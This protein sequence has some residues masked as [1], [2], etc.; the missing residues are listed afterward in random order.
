MESVWFAKRVSRRLTVV[1]DVAHRD[2]REGLQSDRRG[3]D[4]QTTEVRIPA[5][6][7]NAA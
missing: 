1:R 6:I 4:I 2:D 7:P 5:E 3:I